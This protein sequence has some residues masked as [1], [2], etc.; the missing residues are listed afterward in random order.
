MPSI[1]AMVLAGGRVDELDVLTFFRPKS[2]VPFGGLYRIIDFPLSNLMYSGVER[3]GILSQYRSSSLI[4]HIGTGDSWDMT[5]RHRG[6]TLLPPFHGLHAADWYKG[7]ADAVY[8]NLDF[9]RSHKPD[10]VLVLSGDHIYHMDYQEMVRFHLDMKA[11]VTAAFVKVSPVGSTRFGLAHI[12]DDDP[13]GGRILDYVEKPAVPTSNWASLTVYLFRTEVLEKILEENAGAESHEFGRDIVPAVMTRPYRL[14][15]YKFDG[16]WAYSRTL[17]EY[18]AA[19][20]L[21]LGDHPEIALD[22]WGLRTNLDH[23]AIRDRGTAI[24]GSNAR[25]DDVRLHS[26]VRIEGKVTRSILFPGVH[27]EAG[28][29]VRDSI[30]F[31]DS[32]VG[33]GST[34]E[35]TITDI[36]VTIGKDSHIGT[37]DGQLTVIGTRAHIPQGVEIGPGSS[38]HPEVRAEDFTRTR[39]YA[40]AVITAES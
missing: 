25:L 27:V 2:T 4:E 36:A 14:Y 37:S 6:I 35:R 11:D 22:E 18:W 8:Q 29:E 19:N 12:S 16:F 3:I 24:I 30:L 5:G 31:F 28:A 20:M 33:P 15:G 40:G 32:Q 1:L 23:E 9:V 38:I 34:I 10:L 21:L 39:Y 26:G 13:R 7:T 17:E